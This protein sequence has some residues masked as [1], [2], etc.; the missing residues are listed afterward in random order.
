MIK[1]S[2]TST[3]YFWS[4]VNDIYEC[5]PLFGYQETTGKLSYQNLSVLLL[6]EFRHFCSKVNDIYECFPLFGYQET[7][8]KLS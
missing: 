4:E 1:E 8:G 6:T 3:C 2:T 7:I 5:F